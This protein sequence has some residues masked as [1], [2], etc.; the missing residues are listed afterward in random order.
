MSL[1]RKVA[2]PLICLVCLVGFLLL[3][4]PHTAPAALLIVPFGIFF[5]LLY[6][7]SRLVLQLL[8]RT[9]AKQPTDQMA[10]PLIVATVPTILLVLSTV[11]QLTLSDI[12]LALIFGTGMVAYARRAHF[13]RR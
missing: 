2:W 12:F 5:L 10:S 7:T 4:N 3:T 8:T 1:I 13:L 9:W 11:S 6:S